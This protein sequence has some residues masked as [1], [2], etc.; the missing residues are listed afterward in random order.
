[1]YNL[2]DYKIQNNYLVN[3][4]KN[5]KKLVNNLKGEAKMSTTMKVK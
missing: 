5:I 3:D 1:M 4:Y 2:L